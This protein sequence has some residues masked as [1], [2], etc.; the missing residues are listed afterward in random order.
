SHSGEN[1][2]IHAALAG[3]P[4]TG[5]TSLFNALTS[6]YEYVGNWAGVTVEK[7]VGTFVNKQG[8][9]IDLPGIY[10]LT[11][12]SKDEG[13]TTQFL[14]EE[15]FS[16]LLNVVDASQLERNLHLTIQLLEFEKPLILSLNMIDVAKGRG[17][18]IDTDRLAAMIGV[19]VAPVVART[20]RGCPDLLDVMNQVASEP[21]S[22]AAFQ[23]DYG[24]ATKQSISPRTGKL[25]AS[26]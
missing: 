23:I 1:D 11:P 4:N 3:N 19:P 26:P 8:Q 9:L 6:S 17:I 16:L 18:Q 20:G 7:K 5:K 12:L 2:M 14:L 25:A 15:D 22:K 21:E 13:V 10:S 24:P